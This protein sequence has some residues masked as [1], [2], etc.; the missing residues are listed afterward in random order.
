MKANTAF[1]AALPI[2]ALESGAALANTA[3]TEDA[4]QLAIVAVADAYAI[5][6]RLVAAKAAVDQGRR[7][8][9][10]NIAFRTVQSTADRVSGVMLINIVPMVVAAQSVTSVAGVVSATSDR[11][12]V[13]IIAAGQAPRVA[14]DST[15]SRAAPITVARAGGAGLIKRAH[16]QD[17]SIAPR[18]LVFPIVPPFLHQCPPPTAHLTSQHLLS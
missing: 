9:T 6:D 1:Q 17:V 3:R 11:L 7:A 15:A 13:V 10:A 16:R 2:V 4:A 12:A 5:S 14:T 8:A 18:R